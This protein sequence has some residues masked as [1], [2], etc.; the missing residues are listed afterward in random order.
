M[1]DTRLFETEKQARDQIVDKMK[2]DSAISKILDKILYDHKDMSLVA[3][4]MYQRNDGEVYVSTYLV[5]KTTPLAP[6]SKDLIRIFLTYGSVKTFEK[7][8]LKCN[9]RHHFIEELDKRFV[10]YIS[11]N[12]KSHKPVLNNDSK[13]RIRKSILDEYKMSFW[14]NNAQK[15]PYIA[16]IYKKHDIF[17]FEKEL[18]LKMWEFYNSKEVADKAA[19]L[20]KEGNVK[21]CKVSV[22]RLINA[23]YELNMS[24]EEIVEMINEAFVKKLHEV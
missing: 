21:E 15:E 2:S 9:L 16:T 12:V 13:K 22:D 5:W 4:M 19:T 24:L 8:K 3:E 20:K 11:R 23:S 17:R 1:E 7:F 18:V 14:D 6:T 10:S